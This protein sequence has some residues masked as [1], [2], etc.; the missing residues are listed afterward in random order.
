MLASQFLRLGAQHF[1]VFRKP[2]V[3]FDV[4]LHNNTK[5]PLVKKKA[6]LFPV[7]LKLFLDTQKH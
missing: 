3:C 4:I 7:F 6:S 2:D 5:Y 1:C